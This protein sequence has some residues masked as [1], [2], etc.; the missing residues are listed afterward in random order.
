VLLADDDCHYR[1]FMRPRKPHIKTIAEA[2]DGEQAVR[3]A[4]E[5]KPDV[6]PMNLDMPRLDGLQSARRL[7]SDPQD[8]GHRKERAAQFEAEEIYSF[9]RHTE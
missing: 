5:L 4:Q 3:P 8:S 2:V 9:G 1:R 6:V 7:E